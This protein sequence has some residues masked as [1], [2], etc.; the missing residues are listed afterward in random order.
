MSAIIS[1]A[2]SLQTGYMAFYLSTSHINPDD[3]GSIILLLVVLGAAMAYY[4]DNYGY[5]RAVFEWVTRASLG[6]FLG[7]V[8]GHLSE[9]GVLYCAVTGA[10]SAVLIATRVNMWLEPKDRTKEQLASIVAELGSK[11]TEDIA[12]MFEGM[13]KKAT[14]DVLRRAIREYN[15]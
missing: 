6:V 15:S 4:V 2:V 14:A 10:I 9:P 11:E 7:T 12:V 8:V 5:K 3:A 13:G 1:L